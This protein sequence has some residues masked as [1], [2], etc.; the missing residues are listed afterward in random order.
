MKNVFL[1]T[2]TQDQQLGYALDS[3]WHGIP[4]YTKYMRASLENLTVA[5]V[6][7]AVQKHLSAKNLSVVFVT[8]DAAGLKETLIA[9]AFSPIKYDAKAAKEL[10][11][12]D[13]LIGNLKLGIK[14]DAVT[15]TPA[16]KVF[17]E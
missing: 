14:A 6:N 4:E 5:D 15:I 16:A 1:M 3:Q 12:E 13:Q 8:K 10:L 7:K 17:A 11:E 9:D 2:S